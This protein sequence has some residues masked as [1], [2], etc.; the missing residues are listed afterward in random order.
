M[1]QQG[2]RSRDQQ[3]NERVS[4]RV[5]NVRKG[6]TCDRRFWISTDALQDAQVVLELGST[7]EECEELNKKMVDK[8]D[9]IKLETSGNQE[10]IVQGLMSV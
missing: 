6:C 1:R 5:A 9:A 4:W 8:G 3:S 2:A 10:E 7:T